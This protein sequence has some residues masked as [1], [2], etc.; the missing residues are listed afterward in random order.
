MKKE[1]GKKE[2]GKKE[3]KKGTTIDMKITFFPDEKMDDILYYSSLHNFKE[4][5]WISVGFKPKAKDLKTIIEDL[6]RMDYIL[7]HEEYE[8]NVVLDGRK[9]RIGF[10]GDKC[11]PFNDKYCQQGNELKEMALVLNDKKMEAIF[12]FNLSL[13]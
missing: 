4:P 10:T 11:D 5:N 7:D 8:K 3:E 13:N 6:N 1:E 12:E 9:V 2:E